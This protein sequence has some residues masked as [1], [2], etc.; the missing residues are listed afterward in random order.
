MTL[1]VQKLGKP[2]EAHLIRGSGLNI[3]KVVG[4]SNLGFGENIQPRT[5][6]EEEEKTIGNLFTDDFD[7]VALDTLFW[8]GGANVSVANGIC[9]LLRATSAILKHSNS[10]SQANKGTIVL[11][12]RIR[13]ESGTQTNCRF[14]L[15]ISDFSAY[16]FFK[17]QG[18]EN[19]F[20]PETK[21]GGSTTTGSAITFTDDV[22]YIVKIIV[23]SASVEFWVNNV[24]EETIMAD[25]PSTDELPAYAD[26]LR[27]A[28]GPNTRNIKIDWISIN[29][30]AEI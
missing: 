18:T 28:G 6:D 24:L 22:W 10:G 15:A 17:A 13:K 1:E 2:K 26:V 4:S 8:T 29:Y 5:P 20:T 21:T 14:G 19:D 7:G 9:T 16:A 11:E 23:R 25:V 12:A 30:G 27:V 3:P